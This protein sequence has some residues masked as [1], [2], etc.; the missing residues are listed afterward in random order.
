MKKISIALPWAMLLFVTFLGHAQTSLKGTITDKDTAQP[1]EQVEIYLPDIEKGAV[2]DA[3]GHYEMTHLPTGQYKIVA[4]Y[5]GYKTYS[6]TVTLQEGDNTLDVALAPSVV[7]MDE[8]VVSTPFH[9]LERDN[10]MKVETMNMDKLANTGAVTLAEGITKVPGVETVSTGAGIGKP[11]IRGLS[12]NRVL[13]Y[14]QGVRLENQQFG[15]EHGLGLSG[16]GDESVEVIKGPASLLYGSDAMGGVLYINPERFA[17]ANTTK[18][19]VNFD[20]YSNTQG[21]VSNVGVKTSGDKLQFLARAGLSTHTDYKTGGGERVTDSRFRDYDIK[22]GVGYQGSKIKTSLRY[23]LNHSNLG[24]PEEIGEQTTNRKPELPEQKIDNHILSSKTTVFFGKSSLETTLGYTYNIRKEF[25]DS[26]DMAALHMELGTFSYN[27][28]YNLAQMGKLETIVG[29]QGLSQKNRNYGEEALIP[30]ASINDIG[31]LATSHLDWDT[32]GLQFGLRYDHR[33]IDGTEMGNMGEEGYFA[34]IDRNFGSINAAV[35]YKQDF[36]KHFIARLNLA[37]GFRAPNLAELSSNGVHEG[38]NR[39]EIGDNQLDHEQNLQVDF[40]VDFNSE[41]LEFYV[42]AFHNGVSD[43]IFLQPIGEIRDGN[44]VYAYRQQDAKLYGGEIGFHFHPHPLDWL[45]WESSFETVTGKLDDGNYLP[46]IPA[47]SLSNTFRVE[48]HDGPKL[49]N[50][51]AFTTLKSVFDQNK[52]SGFET[53]TSGYNL[54]DVGVG[55]K[56]PV[57]HDQLS[58]HLSANNLLD[59]EY[60]AHLSRLRNDGIANMGRNINLGFRLDI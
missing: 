20:Y 40:G 58:V 30:D 37:S 50:W 47:N 25:E 2:T 38:T 51:Y 10:V 22:T 53:P 23:N 34:P 18:G 1:L 54:W 8:V 15:D 39:Y 13:V 6:G 35:G 41:H 46:L 52:V 36:L 55:G 21:L 14:T 43:Y 60:M 16:A 24:I 3:D 45:H 28:R 11:V 59:K 48:F 44:D 56:L 26:E 31:V 12:S 57:L 33:K 27:L 7:E 32:S 49:K 17:L 29:V 9:K 4:T 19:D 42:N 5:L